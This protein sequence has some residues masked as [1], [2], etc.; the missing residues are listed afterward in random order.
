[1]EEEELKM[2]SYDPHYRLPKY[3]MQGTG[4]TTYIER[5]APIVGLSLNSG[6]V[7]AT[8]LSEASE[9]QKALAGFAKLPEN[10]DGNGSPAFQTE[11]LDS[12]R[13]LLSAVGGFNAPEP[14]IY[15]MTGGGISVEWEFKNR[16]L[17]IE[18]SRDGR[19]EFLFDDGE[20]DYEGIVSS[21][22]IPLLLWRLVYGM[23]R[24]NTA[25]NNE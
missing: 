15:P 22:S 6:W 13:R 16:S 8:P 2:V 12:A 17:D 23:P 9:W 4:A 14:Q 21:D 25:T 20:R 7:Q 18:I 10:W 19:A 5:K 24:A 11:A 3:D 1:M